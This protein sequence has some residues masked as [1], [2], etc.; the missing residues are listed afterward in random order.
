MKQKYLV[1]KVNLPKELLFQMLNRLH[2][3]DPDRSNLPS[4]SNAA[5]FH[6]SELDDIVSGIPLMLFFSYISEHVAC[7]CFRFLNV[8]KMFMQHVVFLYLHVT[9]QSLNWQIIISVKFQITC[10][11]S[12]TLDFYLF[13][14]KTHF[15]KYLMCCLVSVAVAI[16]QSFYLLLA[17]LV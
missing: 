14:C 11:S 10:I 8:Q 7:F 16:Y 9:L 15:S 5:G 4:A 6:I 2:S 17:N 1:D 12:L 13:I 3:Q